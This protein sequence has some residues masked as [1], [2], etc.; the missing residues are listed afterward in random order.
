MFHEDVVLRSVIFG[1]ETWWVFVL[2]PFIA[3]INNSLCWLL[4][5]SD[6]LCPSL[7]SFST[8]LQ[9]EEVVSFKVYGGSHPQPPQWIFLYFFFRRGPEI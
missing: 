3:Y 5:Y 9:P 6:C 7:R 4:C 1:L 8:C 2:F